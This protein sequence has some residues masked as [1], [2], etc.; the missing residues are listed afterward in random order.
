MSKAFCGK[1]VNILIYPHAIFL[2]VFLDCFDFCQVKRDEM[3]KP[4]NQS[5]TLSKLHTAF[6]VA[7]KRTDCRNRADPHKALH[8]P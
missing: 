6:P 2:I 3:V 4:T 1:L 7:A 5:E 8:G